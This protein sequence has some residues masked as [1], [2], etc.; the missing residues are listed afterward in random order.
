VVIAMTDGSTIKYSEQL[1]AVRALRP[2]S[3]RR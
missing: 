3:A 2:G 1:I